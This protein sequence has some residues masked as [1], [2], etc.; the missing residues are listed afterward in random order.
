MQ[1]TI[2]QWLPVN[3]KTT[4]LV[5]WV[6]LVAACT[7]ASADEPS[8]WDDQRLEAWNQAYLDG[9][10][11]D[12]LKLIE[13]DLASESPHPLASC[14]WYETASGLGTL[15]ENTKRLHDT[16]IYERHK[17]AF[18][19]YR[20]YDDVQYRDVVEKFPDAA[21]VEDVMGLIQQRIRRKIKPSDL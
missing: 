1:L 9:R 15:D 21:Q 6:L 14:Y 12:V 8:L 11:D 17:Q 20:H 19:I 7:V 18:E 13:E 2:L 5:V 4:F 3:F 10:R 16:P